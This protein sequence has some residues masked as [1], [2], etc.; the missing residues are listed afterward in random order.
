VSLGSGNYPATT[1][2]R[3]FSVDFD[4]LG[5]LK[6]SYIHRYIYAVNYS[7]VELILSS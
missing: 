1:I 3:D 5:E 7:F 4:Y 2:K 6:L